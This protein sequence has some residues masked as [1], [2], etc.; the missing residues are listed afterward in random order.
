M[1]YVDAIC[2]CKVDLLATFSLVISCTSAVIVVWIYASLPSLISLIVQEMRSASEAVAA[3]A[4]SAKISV[5]Q[6]EL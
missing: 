6:C 4:P 5:S 1:V 2:S 3:G